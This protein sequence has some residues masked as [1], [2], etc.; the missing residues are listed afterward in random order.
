MP[1]ILLLSDIFPPKTGGS[2]RWFWEIYSRLPREQIVVATGEDPRAGDFDRTHDLSVV[3]MPLTMATRGLRPFSNLKRYVSLAW[4]IRGIAK[5]ERVDAIHAARNLP[6]GFIAY[7]VRRISG[8]PYLCYVHGEDVGVSATS[9]ELAWMTRRV[10]KGASLVIANSQNTRSMLLNDWRMPDD[11]LRLLY[12]GVDTKRFV[13]AAVDE[14]IRQSLGWSNRTVLLTVGRLQKRK[15][16][17]TLIQALPTIR[18]KHPNVLYAILGDG[19]EKALLQLLAQAI[20]VSDSVQFLG[21]ASDQQLL[22]CY[23]QCDLFVLPNRS[24]GR[25]VEGFGMVLLEA[26]A[27]GKPVVAGASGGT[28]ETMRVI[29]SGRIV[30]CETPDPLASTINDLLSNRS[31]LVQMGER[32]RAWVC[33]RFDWEALSREA[34]EV[35]QMIV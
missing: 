21:E 24:I 20:G 5:R 26:Q 8:I 2:G 4:Q 34:A 19:E 18:E 7:L 33:E 10:L 9:R 11:K 28:A 25:D 35:F 3:R 6:E 17:D 1:R 32:G 31:Q 30:P 13:P 27:C 14:S 29:E 23:Q 22:Q 16:H 12:P 15:G